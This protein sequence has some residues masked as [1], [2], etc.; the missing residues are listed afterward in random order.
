MLVNH[1][2]ETLRWLDVNGN[3]TTNPTD[4]DRV[5]VG[6]ANPDFTGGI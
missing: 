3:L 5:R 4:A 2:Q 6:T 1:K